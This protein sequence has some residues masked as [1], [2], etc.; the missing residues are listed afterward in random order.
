MQIFFYNSDDMLWLWCKN[1]DYAIFSLFVFACSFF[2]VTFTVFWTVAGSCSCFQTQLLT[3][4][5]SV[6]SHLEGWTLIL[7]LQ[8][9]AD[10]D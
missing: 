8:N 1:V 4:L 10:F 2:F 6:C 3:G 5:L 7:P 9:N